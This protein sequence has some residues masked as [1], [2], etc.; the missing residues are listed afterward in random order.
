MDVQFRDTGGAVD[1]ALLRQDPIIVPM[2]RSEFRVRNRPTGAATA[3]LL[4]LW[5]A[6][7]PQRISLL[8][9]GAGW[10]ATGKRACPT[11]APLTA[12]TY[13]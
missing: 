10:L 3:K 5:L 1:G 6:P 13:C 4:S 11:R 8:R 2:V 7:G 9:C 12:R